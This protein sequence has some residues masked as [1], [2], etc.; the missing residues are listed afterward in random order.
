[1]PEGSPGSIPE[2]A[3]WSTEFVADPYEAF[4]YL[5]K[6]D[7]VWY[8]EPTDQWIISR[9]VDVNALLRDRRL[10]RSYLHVATPEE[11]GLAPEP[12]HL[13]PFWKLVRD[14]MLDREPP[15]H[16]RLRRLVSKA[17]TA[18]MVEQLRPR[19]QQI[20]DG[21][22][23]DLLDAGSDGSSVD[24]LAT[25]LEPLPVTIIAEMLGIPETDW[26]LLRPWSANIVGGFELAPTREV[27][28]AAVRASV[29][30]SD[31]LREL[32]RS[33]RDAPGSDLISA[34]T[35]VV[36]SGDALTEDE[37]IGTCVLL[38]NAGHEATVNLNGAGWWALFRNPAE[39]AR[40]R[41]D[42][43]LLPSA[44]EELTRFDTSLPMFERWVLSDI[45]VHGV[46][47]PRGKEV[48][49]LLGSANRDPE[50]F[51]GPDRLDLGRESNPHLTF[52]AGIHFCLGAPLA[53]VELLAS[54]A[55][56]LDR[57]PG[58]TL[59]EQPRWKPSFIARGL[60]SLMVTVR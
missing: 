9:Y 31:Y 41:A 22:V 59:V 58:M 18:R 45:E 30:F 26:H 40:L 29:E 34:L 25:V 43:E 56:L 20:V 55:T 60:E 35:Q 57:V 47:I 2:F 54:Y 3:P 27:Q 1:M 15:D 46:R 11:M 7:P 10:G 44:V 6:H 53:R 12:E 52:G 33:R 28:D 8:F 16:T 37:L 48:G 39:L 49:L 23:D 5:R 4:A 13:A 50:V 14:G 21:L 42:R 38:L 17:F 32:A 24:L 36:D 51:A 19:V